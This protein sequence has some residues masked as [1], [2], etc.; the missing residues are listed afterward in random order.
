MN[1]Y[2]HKSTPFPH[3]AELFAA[4]RDTEAWGIV[5]EQGCGKTKPAWDTTAWLFLAGKINGLL[6]VAPDGV[7]RNWLSDELPR[8]L[9]DKVAAVTRA[10]A[11]KSSSASAQWHAAELEGL[12]RWNGLS[13]LCISYNA[14]MSERGKRFVWR[15]LKRRQCLYVLDESHF[16]KSPGAKRTISVIASG[17]Y[18]PYRRILTGTPIAQ[19]PFDL[20]SQLKFLNPGFWAHRGIGSF[21]AYKLQGHLASVSS[22]LT[23]ESAGLNLPP[24]L[25]TRRYVELTAAQKR[26]YRE[27]VETYVAELES[28]DVVEADLAIVRL[29][30]LQQVICGYVAVEAGEPT[31]PIDK[32][33]PRLNLALEICEALPHQ[34]ILWARFQQDVR[35]LLDALGDRAAGYS[36]LQNSDQRARS[37]AAFVAGDKQF[38]VSN[39]AVGGTGLTFLMAKTHVYYSNSFNLVERQQSEDRSH[40]IG[41]DVSVEY[42]DLVAEGTVDEKIISMLQAKQDIASKITGDQLKE[43]LRP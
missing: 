6:V 28:G 1:V 24:K 29:L 42:I 34:A 14:F 38:L 39:P 41:Q 19:G 26:V 9:P 13:V 16:I 22:R 33:N 17:K 32:V 15:Y 10:F 18:A 31:Q 20:Y 35:L 12:L 2:E 7:H 5:W 43:W 37:K 27:L 11:Y 30:R 4:T 8:H 23:K 3:Q 21:A 40:R 25:Y 36:G